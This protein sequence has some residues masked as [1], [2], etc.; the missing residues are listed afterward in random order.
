MSARGDHQSVRAGGSCRRDHDQRNSRLHRLRGPHRSS[1]FARPGS[2]SR[3]PTSSAR[4]ASRI[5]YGAEGHAQRGGRRER[6]TSLSSTGPRARGGRLLDRVVP[7]QSGGFELSI[8]P[9]RTAS[10]RARLAAGPGPPLVVAV[11]PK[12]VLERTAW[13][14]RLATVS[15]KPLLP[16]AAIRLERLAASSWVSVGDAVIGKAGR[17]ALRLRVAPGVYRA[18]IVPTAGLAAGISRPLTIVAT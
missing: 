12:I 15:V 2:R 1:G 8:R 10:Y 5:V 17:F 9:E 18:R 11:A 7:G 4:R 14:G 16:G 3:A 13:R 6:T